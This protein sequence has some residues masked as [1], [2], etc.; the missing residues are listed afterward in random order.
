[1]E[2]VEIQRTNAQNPPEAVRA[3]ALNCM[4]RG[5]VTEHAAPLA[6][7]YLGDV[8]ALASDRADTRSGSEG[9]PIADAL[10]TVAVELG[11]IAQGMNR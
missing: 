9:E 7:I 4:K 2:D 8:L 3:K 1:M 6:L 10:R 5:R 11:S